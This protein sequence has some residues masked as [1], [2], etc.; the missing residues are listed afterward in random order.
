V[1]PLERAPSRMTCRH[2][3]LMIAMTGCDSRAGREPH[4]G[5]LRVLI[6]VETVKTFAVFLQEVQREDL[7]RVLTKSQDQGV[8]ADEVPIIV[9]GGMRRIT[10]GP[11]PNQGVE[12]GSV[13]AAATDIR[14]HHEFPGEANRG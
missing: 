11:G 7:S 4:E 8:V 10:R 1:A 3:V 6:D 5:Q 13:R 2:C 12:P 9:L 14:V